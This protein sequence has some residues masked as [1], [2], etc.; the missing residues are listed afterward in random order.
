MCKKENVITNIK[1][2]FSP[3]HRVAQLF[4]LAPYT[5][6][7]NVVDGTENIDISWNSNHKNVIWSFLLLLT[8]SLGIVYR[9]ALNFVKPATP[10]SKLLSGVVHLPLVQSTGPVAMLFGLIRNRSRMSQVVIKLSSVDTF[11]FQSDDKVYRKHNTFLVIII[12]CSVMYTFPLYFLHL[13][14]SDNTVAEFIL[15]LSHVTWLVN[16]VQ[17]LN[18]LVI[19]KDRLVAVNEKLRTI[20][21]IDSYNHKGFKFSTHPISQY[22]LGSK[23]HSEIEVYSDSMRRSVQ[24][25]AASEATFR[26]LTGIASQILKFRQNYNTLYEICGL[27]NS[28]HGCTILLNWSVYTVS[29]IVNLYHV[30]IF[31]FLPSTSEKV[32]SS[33][34]ENVALILWDVLILI[35]MLVIAVTCQRACDERQRCMSNLQDLQLEYIM[36]DDVLIQLE[37]FSDQLVNNK[38]EFTACGIFPMNLSVLC[39]VVGLVVQYLIVLFQM[40]SYSEHS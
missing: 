9:L 3:V 22:N 11:L 20:Y 2:A 36:E 16:D 29:F 4:G 37:S 30:S 40:R 34:V 25:S 14:L 15:V 7:R 5:F 13:W 26:N 38:I 18:L 12:T 19:L 17:Y 31:Y 1:L 6:V 27:I 10:V 35:R 32:L 23:T 39:S 21:I 8:Q 28:M 33:T 24:R